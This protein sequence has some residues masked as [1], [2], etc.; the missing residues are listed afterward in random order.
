MKRSNN[1]KNGSPIKNRNLFLKTRNIRS[2]ANIA[3]AKFYFVEGMVLHV[4]KNK[5]KHLEQENLCIYET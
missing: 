5:T 2:K 4:E 1:P 3:T